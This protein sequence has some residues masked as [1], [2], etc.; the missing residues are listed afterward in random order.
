MVGT[1]GEKICVPAEEVT[2]QK[3]TNVATWGIAGLGLPAL[4]INF[5]G[6]WKF[7]NLNEDRSSPPSCTQPAAPCQGLEDGQNGYVGPGLSWQAV[8]LGIA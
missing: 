6:I 4:P 2:S 1:A 7:G 8:S 5:K 3:Q